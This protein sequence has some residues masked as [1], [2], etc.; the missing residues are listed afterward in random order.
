MIRLP[1]LFH[2]LGGAGPSLQDLVSLGVIAFVVTTAAIQVAAR[3]LRRRGRLAPAGR[4]LAFAAWAPF[5][6]AACSFGA[7]VI[8]LAVIGDHLEEFANFGLAFAVLATFQVAWSI[9]YVMGPS[10]ALAAVA[11]VVNLGTAFVWLWS[12]TIGLPLGPDP[13]APEAAGAADLISTLLELVLVVVLVLA[14]S[15]GAQRLQD[16]LRLPA[17]VVLVAGGYAIGAVVLA[18]AVALLS[19]SG[20][21]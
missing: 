19:L 3:L 16:R 2:H 12:R 14:A 17:T 7:A 20:P 11:I 13:G 4:R 10:P 6:A 21:A 5:V 15:R 9:A 18:T 1:V 8:H